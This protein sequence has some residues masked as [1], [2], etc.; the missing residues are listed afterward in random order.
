[1]RF[2]P[3]RELSRL[4]RWRRQLLQA[5]RLGRWGDHSEKMLA[6]LR[7]RI[8]EIELSFETID[9]HRRALLWRLTLRMCDL[10]LAGNDPILVPRADSIDGGPEQH[11]GSE[12]GAIKE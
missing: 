8:D 7:Q 12:H 4:H 3:A 11:V 1:M 6:A 2:T 5:K 10:L 9:T